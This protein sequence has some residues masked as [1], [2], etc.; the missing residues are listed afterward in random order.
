MGESLTILV[1]RFLHIGDLPNGLNVTLVVII[2]KVNN[3]NR[4]TQLR[5]ISL[6]NISYKEITKTTTNRLKE[7]MPNIIGSFQSSF[8]S[9]RHITENIIIY[10]EILNS[11]RRKKGK[12]GMMVLKI[13]LEKT[14]DRLS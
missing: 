4:V 12:A 8:V 2:P 5:S 3:S 6:C 14:Y 1:K 9:G 11:M 13:D 7:I 10:Q